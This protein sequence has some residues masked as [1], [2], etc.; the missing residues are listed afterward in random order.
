MVMND[1]EMLYNKIVLRKII[2]E[3]NP[4]ENFCD[5]LLS[6][7]NRYLKRMKRIENKDN[8]KANRTSQFSGKMPVQHV[9]ILKSEE[10]RNEL[11]SISG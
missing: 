2:S 6:L 1:A 11:S 10:F 7:N 4:N 9:P 3:P 8:T 5:L